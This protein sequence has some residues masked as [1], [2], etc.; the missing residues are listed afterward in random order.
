MSASLDFLTC[1]TVIPMFYLFRYECSLF[2]LAPT[3]RPGHP[4]QTILLILY[5]IMAS[6][7]KGS[8]LQ[9]EFLSSRIFI[10]YRTICYVTNW[11]KII[12][13]N[14]LIKYS[15]PHSITEV[16]TS[17]GSLKGDNVRNLEFL[18]EMS[19]L[20]LLTSSPFFPIL[21]SWIFYFY[22]EIG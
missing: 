19:L 20:T 6:R 9:Q 16:R 18:V 2:F 13:S 3:L 17:F 21:F 7:K 12:R 22:P 1:Y 4:M 14:E 5:S 8:D 10:I 11:R 15:L